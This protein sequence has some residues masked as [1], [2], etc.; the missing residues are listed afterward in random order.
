MTELNYDP[1]SFERID[2]NREDLR[3][4]TRALRERR[5]LAATAST[6]VQAL[7][8]KL[9][10]GDDSIQPLDFATAKAK[11]EMT[12]LLVKSAESKQNTVERAARVRDLDVAEAVAYELAPLLDGASLTVTSAL[13]KT[14]PKK[15]LPAAYVVQ[16]RPTEHLGDGWIAGTAE[17]TLA[18]DTK[19]IQLP[20]ARTLASHLEDSGWLNPTVVMGA[21]AQQGGV[22]V[23][24]MTVTLRKGASAGFG[25][26]PRLTAIHPGKM[27]PMPGGMDALR[28]VIGHALSHYHKA[29]MGGTLPLIEYNALTGNA[30]QP[31]R[32]ED[33]TLWQD[34]TLAVIAR[35]AEGSPLSWPAAED[36]ARAALKDLSGFITGLGR[37]HKVMMNPKG[38]DTSAYMGLP[39]FARVTIAYREDFEPDE[40]EEFDA[41]DYDGEGAE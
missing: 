14:F 40:V 41:D 24:R 9:L 18:A 36:A 26:T 39:V 4:A 19:L 37:I 11:A 34:F 2:Q 16:S 30:T 12:E 8:S 13:P 15:T 1:A 31:V 5:K 21:Q 32:H 38:F 10:H 17:V 20:T 22:W 3:E 28:S 25:P 23:N 7:T 27:P 35:P 29:R 6:D 33:G